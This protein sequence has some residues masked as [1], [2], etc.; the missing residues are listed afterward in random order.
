MKLNQSKTFVSVLI[1]AFDRKDKI[2][3]AINSVLNQTFKYY[4]IIIIDDG[5]T[6][7]VEKIIFPLLKKYKFIK[8]LRHSNRGTA[9]SLNSGIQI[10][11]GKYITFLDSDDEYEINHIELRA[12]YFRKNP[13][14]YLIH[15]TCKFICEEED[16]FIPDA[17]NPKKLIHLSKCVIGATFFGKK[18]VFVL[19]GFK[20]CYG[21]DYEFYLRAKKY[22]IVK[23]LD[24]PTYIYHRE[25]KDSVLTKM[26]EKISNENNR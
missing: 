2:L 17:R 9:F 11:E 8:Y 15:T 10:A 6:D 23:K 16:L 12:E 13:D 21:Y 19:K 14:T 24:L 1:T 5:S 3:R 26:K 20:N 22:F 25:S 18:N 7:G 4:E